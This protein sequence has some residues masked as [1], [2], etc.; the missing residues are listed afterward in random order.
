MVV[1]LIKN[2]SIEAE[3]KKKEKVWEARK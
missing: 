2:E 1:K 3:G